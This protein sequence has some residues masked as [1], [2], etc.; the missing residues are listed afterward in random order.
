MNRRW[1]RGAQRAVAGLGLALLGGCAGLPALG[2]SP[3]PAETPPPA[4]AALP[5]PPAFQPQEL[6]GRWGYAA[7]HRP[8][9]RARTEAAARRA[10]NR[11]Y[12]IARGP[13]GGVM[14][15]LA[16]ETQPT[17]LVL[18]GSAE[19]KTYIGPGPQPAAERDREVVSFDGRVLVLRWVD[20]EVQGRYGYGVFVRCAP[21]A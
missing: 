17:E 10:C 21:R 16:D 9:D 7:Y 19:G 2:P 6:V 14:M 20:E 11:P 8:D 1:Q 13:G 3:R 15:H 12:V 4:P 5:V 18:K